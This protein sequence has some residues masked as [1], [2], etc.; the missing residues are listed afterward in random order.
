MIKEAIGVLIEGKDLTYEEAYFVMGEIMGGEAA[1][2]QVGAFLTAL[3]AKGETADEIAGL[4][5]VM[6][7]KATPVKIS[8]PAI[9]VVGTGGDSSGSF[10]ISTAAA[11]VVAG[12][13]L[14]VAKHGNRAMTSK[15]GSAD[16]LEAVGVKIDLSPE[17]VAECIEKVG[18]G[19]M[20]AQAFHPAMKHAAPVRREIGIR[21]V[22]N[23]LGP[24]TNPAGVEHIMLGVPSEE[25]GNKIAAVLHRLGI[26]HGLVVHGKDGLDEISIS[27]KSVIWDITKKKLSTPYEVSPKSFGYDK[28]DIKEI[29][30]G[31]P[32]ENAATL[33]RILDGDKGVLRN[34]VVMNAAAALVAG[35]AATE[36]KKAV[37][38]AEES[39]DSGKA[40]EKLD[41]LIKLSQTL[42]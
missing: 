34:I 12:S 28:A 14:K 15:C 33:L 10:N 31:T 35:N 36:L 30:G 16:I 4:A 9:D 42:K 2:A 11:F 41:M 29:R 18:I 17:G 27:D 38:L 7:A 5:S 26:K 22:F 3:R 23:I 24:L 25:V 6:R 40:R 8:G 21:T 1:P 19:Y 37:V 39:I 32:E 20:F 13:G